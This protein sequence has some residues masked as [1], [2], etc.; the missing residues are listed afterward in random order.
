MS[1]IYGLIEMEANCW[2]TRWIAAPAVYAI[3][4][5]DGT[6]VSSAAFILVGK[7]ITLRIS[8]TFAFQIRA[9]LALQFKSVWIFF[10]FDIF[11]SNFSGLNDYMSFFGNSS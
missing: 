4:P 10:F 2:S 6:R 1:H 5:S 3:G 7:E 9:Y 8:G 11:H